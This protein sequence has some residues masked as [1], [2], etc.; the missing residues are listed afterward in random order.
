[1]CS[2]ALVTFDES[3]NPLGLPAGLGNLP[4]HEE[5]DGWHS[6]LGSWKGTTENPVKANEESP[7]N[8]YD[9]PIVPVNPQKN[10]RPAPILIFC[11]YQKC[12]GNRLA[13]PPHQV[14]NTKMC[15]TVN[16]RPSFLRSRPIYL[17]GPQLL[18]VWHLQ[19]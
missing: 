9:I 12:S 17:R 14:H 10:A 15:A 2:L 16:Q 11:Q 19:D 6:V 3:H 13:I 7:E 1:M 5:Q 8:N 4:L 18:L